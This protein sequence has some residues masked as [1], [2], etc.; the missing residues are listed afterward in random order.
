MGPRC[1]RRSAPL[2]LLT[3]ALLLAFLIELSPHLVHHLFEEHSAEHDCPFAT[4]GE[5]QAGAI[6]L[7]AALA[8]SDGPTASAVLW[9]GATLA[10]R[11]VALP[12]SRAPPPRTR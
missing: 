7:G 12:A 6:G 11:P 8:S 4:A 3:A 2:A 9:P 5:H 10:P 1:G